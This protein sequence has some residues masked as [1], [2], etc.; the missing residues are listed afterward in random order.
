MTKIGLLV[1][2]SEYQP[3]L[4]PLPSA[5]KDV[6][7]LKEVL[8]HPDMGGFAQKDITVL[9][10][11]DRQRMEEAIEQLF[12]RRHKND[13]VLLFFSGHGI[14]DETNR[15]YLATSN[16]RKTNR[17]DLIRSSA[18]PASFIHDNMNRS[19]SKR[20]VVILDSCFSGAFAEGLSA[21]DDGTVNIREE[22]GGEGWAI[23][24][25]STSTQ[26]SFEQEGSELSLYT[27]YLIQGI[28]TG[29][30]DLDEDGFVSL[31]ELHNYASEKVQEV[32]PT[33]M[34]PEIYPGKEGYTIRL[35]K[36][37]PGDPKPKYKK[38]VER[39]IS[40]GEVTFVGRQ[41]LDV[42]R[43]R[44]ALSEVEAKAI[45]DEILASSR[46]KFKKKLQQYEQA[47]TNL[48]QQE[49]APSVDD[50]NKLREN[51]QRVLEL[52]NEDTQ[53]IESRVRSQIKTFKQHLIQYE[54]ALA[55]V[56]RKEY[57]LSQATRDRLQQMQQQW[58][59]TD[60]DIASIKRRVSD[61]IEAY[62]EKLQQY[63]QA[64]ASAIE[65]QYPLT[66]T[67]RNELRQ[68]QQNLGLKDEDIAPI[69]IRIT[70]E[71]QA[72]QE[73]LQKY[74][75]VF[76]RSIQ[77]E[78]PLN[79]EVREE[80]KRFQHVL[81][82]RDEDVAQIE[83]KVVSQRDIS[84]PSLTPVASPKPPTPPLKPT[85]SPPKATTT[86][87]SSEEKTPV[88]GGLI[89]RRGFLKW[90]VLSFIGAGIAVVGRT[91]FKG[92]SPTPIKAPQPQLNNFIFEVV[93][94]NAWG[95]EIDR[96]TKQARYFTENLGYGVDLE[97]IAIPKGTF[98]MGSPKTYNEIPQHKVTVPPFFMGKHEVTQA[99]W[100][101][102]A[103]LPKVYRYL[104]AN[105]SK[106]PGD[107]R[108]VEHVS[109]DDAIEFCIRLSR[110]TG[111]KYRLPSE[112]EWEYACRA[113]TTTPFYFGQTITYWL[114]NYGEH[115]NETTDVGS[116]LPNAFGL[117]DMHGNVSD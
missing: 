9:K 25:S 115:R 37:P 112:A 91:L 20:K 84:Q 15:L 36:V 80:L 94:V 85:T 51:L 34:K 5:V 74:E 88:S 57:P 55:E 23:L 6:E 33:T 58:Q 56:M 62:R 2:V 92:D 71:I 47:F 90:G 104:K 105:P 43:D 22:L 114:A 99:Q 14:K 28:K 66:K 107:N 16:T 31:G 93:T 52:R 39:Y 41:I 12:A 73:K 81:E 45:E 50:L 76:T 75:Q 46:Q 10:N 21:K 30:A 63:E 82:L 103:N 117:L 53:Q 106:F 60:K 42:L 69:K 109:W 48:F 8:Q 13:L 64:F 116:F 7:A 87:P 27:K 19:R 26:Y 17:G 29:E 100:R 111:R 78:Y 97:L 72:Y 77:Q 24:T 35:A 40:R 1:G 86:R 49:V 32:K 38:E 101:A 96:I 67:K 110:K 59:L 113:G 95:Q 18:V 89:N 70:A 68:Q 79:D 3:G 11:P 44:L 108:P 102:V 65:Q 83:A 61:E 4:N 54:K 98:T